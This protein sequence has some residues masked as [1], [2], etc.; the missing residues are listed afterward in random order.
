MQHNRSDRA[1]VRCLHRRSMSVSPFLFS[2]RI[3]TLLAIYWRKHLSRKPIRPNPAA[4]PKN[5]IVFRLD[6]LGDL[7][8][9]TPLFRE[10]KRIFPN[11]RC[12]VVVQRRYRAILTTNR[13]IDEILPIDEVKQ[14][15][16]PE[17]V[18]RLFSATWFFWTRLRHRQF[19]LA[20]SPRWDVDE[21]LAT[22]LS[23]LANAGT[24]VGHSEHVAEAK[25]RINRGFDAA[26][27]VP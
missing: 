13:H 5:I 10:L 27:D 7:V 20:I 16:L 18:K 6:Q 22:M 3:P 8:L 2:V 11:S 15:W 25:C 12:T 1:V 17:G 4:A 21:D 19:D 9:S 14:N 23:A 26:F 24:R